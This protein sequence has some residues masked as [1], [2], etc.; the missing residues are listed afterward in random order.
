M[1]LACLAPLTSADNEARRQKADIVIHLARCRILGLQPTCHPTV[2]ESASQQFVWAR[3]SGKGDDTVRLL[4]S[5][6]EEA[7]DV[8]IIS[9]SKC[10]ASCRNLPKCCDAIPLISLHDLYARFH[11]GIYC[12]VGGGC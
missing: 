4:T 7:N 12:D 2:L 6:L 3:M 11:G 1:L 5:T 10:F 8:L 9:F